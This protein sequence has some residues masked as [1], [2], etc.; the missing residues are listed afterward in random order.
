MMNYSGKKQAGQPAVN[1]KI[2]R[3]RQKKKRD[4]RRQA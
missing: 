3:K 4:A 1:T 2:A